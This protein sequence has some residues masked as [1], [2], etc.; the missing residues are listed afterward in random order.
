MA[1][2]VGI[3]RVGSLG[4][5]LIALPLYRRLRG[6]HAR[7]RLVLVS[8]L[9]TAGNPK[10]VG[11]S[12]VL[13]DG[14]F[15]EYLNYPVG[16]DWRSILRKV[17]LFRGAQL[18]LLYY[19]MPMRTPRQ[20]A[21]DG[22]FFRFLG[23]RVIGLA[24]DVASGPLQYLESSGRYE[25]ESARLARGI[26]ALQD[27]LLNSPESRSMGIT[28][29]EL[30]EARSLLGANSTVT[31]TINIGGKFEVKDWGVENW[32]ELIRRLA[33]VENIGR[34]VFIGSA[35]EADYSER[36]RLLWPRRSENFCG[37]IS[38]RLS[39]AVLGQTQ[40]FVGHDSG[41]MHMAAAVN[42]PIVAIFCSRDP[43][44][45]WFPL[46]ENAR[47]H[48]TSIECM[49]CGRIRCEDRQQ[50]C[51]RR[52]TVEEVFQSCLAALPVGVGGR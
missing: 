26:Q 43:K 2:R 10:L 21:R 42:V 30:N 31:V 29:S 34:L 24:S 4:D 45:Q 1:Q 37:K 6:L 13:P 23:L 49:G 50:E 11:P 33:S 16:S 44:G 3:L 32:S 22:L 5:H 36:L 25:H 8:N 18:A 46:S 35:D 39:A 27:G 51:I 28:D 12:S 40:L 17:R 52:I 14:L 15:D 7:D 19:L 41:P 9:P 48:Y 47:V 20:L 38:P